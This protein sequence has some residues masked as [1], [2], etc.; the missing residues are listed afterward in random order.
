MENLKYL[1]QA[2]I[3]FL[4]D[5]VKNNL[6]RYTRSDF[7][8]L[9]AQGGWN[10]ELSLRVDLSP[11]EKLNSDNNSDAEIENTLL[12][13]N[14]LHQLMPSLACEDRLWARLTH[15]ECLEFSRNR[16]L[17]NISGGDLEKSIKK[18]FFANTQ[19]RYRDDNAVSR[20][21]WN[22][23]IAKQAAPDNQEGAIRMMLKS[24]D[25]R[26]NF[27]ER[28]RTVSRPCLAAGIIRIMMSESWL[29]EKERN[30]RDFMIV[31]N[32]MGGGKVFEVWSQSEI[33]EFM[34]YCLKQAKS[35]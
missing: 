30:Y 20:L 33:D 14:V 28:T 21:W 22:A 16:W 1:S 4:H 24:A 19:T 15:V 7:L 31:L 2:C 34:N 18:H 32:R 3:D 35:Y 13:W 8:D 6:D 11:L 29:T 26:S 5:N 25:I 27:I 23:F 9:V 17:R 12:V 10:I